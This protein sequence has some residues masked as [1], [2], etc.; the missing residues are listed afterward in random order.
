[1]FTLYPRRERTTKQ[2]FALGG[3]GKRRYSRHRP[4]GSKFGTL[5]VLTAM[6]AGGVYA[7]RTYFHRT[8]E[9][10]VPLIPADAL[11]VVTLDTTP[12]PAQTPTF[13]RIADAIKNEHLDA[14]LEDA[15]AH[16]MANSPIARDARP[17]TTGS[18]A[19]ATLKSSTASSPNANSGDSAVLVAINDAGKV[20][21]VLNRD[22]QKTNLNGLDYY[23]ATGDTHCMAVIGNYLV[24]AD[25]PEDLARIEAV[26]KGETPSIDTV[27]DYQ[28]ARAGLPADSNLMLF[29]SANGVAQATQGAQNRAGSSL[30]SRIGNTRPNARYIAVGMAVHE[31]GID[32]VVQIPIEPVQG[33]AGSETAHIAPLDSNLW[34]KLP[35]GAYGVMAL[36][37]PGKYYNYMTAAANDDRVVRRSVQEGVSQFE[38]ETG[39]SVAHDILPGTNGD[40]ALAVYP[41]AD[42]AQ[43]GLDGVIVLDDANSADPA[44]LADH[45]RAYIERA[46]ARNQGGQAW[47]F[48]SENR[49]GATIWSLDTTSRQAFQ[50]SLEG[51][52]MDTRRNAGFAPPPPMPAAPTP[53]VPPT[54][55]APPTADTSAANGDPGQNNG[56]S[57]NRSPDNNGSNPTDNSTGSNPTGNN[58]GSDSGQNNANPSGNRN[59]PGNGSGSE[60][61]TNEGNSNGRD[62][63]SGSVSTTNHSPGGQGSSVDLHIHADGEGRVFDDSFALH[64]DGDSVHINHNGVNIHSH[65]GDAVDINRNG[66]NIHSHDG[67]SLVVGH[68]GIDLH[69]TDAANPV[70]IPANSEPRDLGVQQA[71]SNKTITWAQIGHAVVIAT[72]PHMLDRAIAAYT[73]G[74][75]SLADDSG[76]ASMRQRVPAGA[77]NA[78]MLNLPSILETLRP[79]ITQAMSGNS[80]GLN[81]DDVLHLAGGTGNGLVSTQQYDGKTLKMT[82]FL[83]LDYEKAIHL[84]GAMQ[85]R[86]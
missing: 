63:N 85:S 31:Q 72:S 19:I 48:T 83:P 60:S 68:G 64:H 26:R 15:L 59:D 53:P 86:R 79:L 56:N 66:V 5:L 21:D 46:S 52:M 74:S 6:T 65:D 13:K 17:F 51:G 14:Q 73:S 25:K 12:S 18:L 57:E 11:M 55:P 27:A 81:A 8:G 76:F 61:N 70:G 39:L 45:V 67:S 47:H 37:Q 41:D 1:M 82:L 50:R 44:S 58:G 69:A 24:T 28:Q 20:T 9:A 36:S 23:K 22:A 77:Q 54:P 80:M 30:L 4:G 84:A 29:F 10:A 42:D 78:L 43:K 7:Y 71:V 38:H 2:T 75:N 35:G 33:A 49:N 62:A 16:N 32:T 40:A 34:R 3:T